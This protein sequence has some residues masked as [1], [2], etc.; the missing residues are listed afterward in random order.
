MQVSEISKIIIRVRGQMYVT[1]QAEDK[2]ELY[3]D[4]IVFVANKWNAGYFETK[5]KFDTILADDSK[6]RGF[7]SLAETLIEIEVE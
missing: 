7:I 2:R 1:F 6:N 5:E 4:A 3:N